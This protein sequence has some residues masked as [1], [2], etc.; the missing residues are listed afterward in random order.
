MKLTIAIAKGEEYYLGTI[1]EIPGVI[2]QGNTI[3]ETKENLMDAL[4]LYLEAMET[5]SELEN[6]VLE[7]DLAINYVS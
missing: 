6:I 5:E 4:Q 7:E 2:T 3:E 1:K